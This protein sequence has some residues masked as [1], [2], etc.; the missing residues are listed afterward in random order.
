MIS[1]YIN[2]SKN[3]LYITNE[4]VISKEYDVELTSHIV[5]ERDI[6]ESTLITSQFIDA[7]S[8][9]NGVNGD[10]Q[11]K[12]AVHNMKINV[13]DYCDNIYS[14]SNNPQR[15]SLLKKLFCKN[16]SEEDRSDMFLKLVKRMFNKDN[17]NIVIWHKNRYNIKDPV[18]TFKDETYLEYV[19]RK[20][21]NCDVSHELRIENINVHDVE[22]M[23]ISIEDIYYKSST[24]DSQLYKMVKSFSD[25]SPG[26]FFKKLNDGVPFGMWL[27]LKTIETENNNLIIEC[28]KVIG[29]LFFDD[30]HIF[31]H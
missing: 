31:V 27:L 7:F 16:L 17:Y 24:F 14:V 9:V 6:I 29:Y 22:K 28:R 2:H 25:E 4:S 20:I 1:I 30:E 11:K 15:I 10:D 3:G 26:I 8:N 23:T 5:S 13:K 19:K 18:I 21:D 12:K